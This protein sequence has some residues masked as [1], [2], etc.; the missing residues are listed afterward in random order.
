MSKPDALSRRAFL[1][2]SSQ[3][4]AAVAVGSSLLSMTQPVAA[5]SLA[6][7]GDLG[8]PNSFGMR[9]P[10]GF[11]AR[12]IARAGQ[13]LEKDRWWRRTRYAWHSYP[14]GG[15]TYPTDDGGWIYVSN[16]ETL[17]V[18]GGG[19]SAVRFDYRGRVQDA[20]RI[21]GGTNL[22]CA[23]GPTPW[24]TWLSCEEVDLGRVFECDP[25]GKCLPIPRPALGA[26]KHEAVAVDTV[27]G[28]LYLTED[29]PDGRLYRFIPD[30]LNADGNLNLE[31]G[32]LQVAAVDSQ[33]H[34]S[35]INLP[36]PTPNL[37]Q[38]RTRAQVPESTAFNGGE[39][40][41]FSEGRII[42]TTKGDN[43]VWS[44]DTNLQHLDVIY[45]AATAPNPVLTG[46]DN[47]TT[48]SGGDILVAEDGG[49]MQ[50]VVIDGSGNVAPLMQIVGQADSEITGPAF[51]PDYSRLYFSSQRG[52][53]FN[54]GNGFGITYE[55]RGPFERYMA[56]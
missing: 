50:I 16:S 17:S 20:Y 15:A 25:Y 48:S 3:G 14:D 13:T 41:W 1:G 51:S 46:V 53:I 31:S 18:L 22:N 5:G 45:D 38:T 33:G 37:F 26:F 47:V 39:G 54:G 43:R 8:A 9:L 19:A 44:L 56:V 27:F 12:I 30:G 11:S 7:L 24:H 52:G 35:W 42:F 21:L 36:N 34:V 29:E 10:E 32:T 2:K 49:D 28:H 23:G 55:I 40:I 4:L 6:D